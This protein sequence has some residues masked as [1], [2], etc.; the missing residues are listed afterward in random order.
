MSVYVYICVFVCVFIYMCNTVHMCVSN[1]HA[2]YVYLSLHA[3]GSVGTK[4]RRFGNLRRLVT[5]KI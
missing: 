4:V 5:F 1:I 3:C 2:L